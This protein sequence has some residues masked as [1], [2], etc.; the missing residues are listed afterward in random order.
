ML[1]DLTPPLR[2]LQ[3]QPFSR[4]FLPIHR[5]AAAVVAAVAGG[6]V[7]ASLEQLP[8][9]PQLCIPAGTAEA[10]TIR[11]EYLARARRP[12]PGSHCLMASTPRTGNAVGKAGHCWNRSR[13]QEPAPRDHPGPPTTGTAMRPH[14][15][16]SASWWRAITKLHGGRKGGSRTGRPAEPPATTALGSLRDRYSATPR[17]TPGQHR[18]P[19]LGAGGGYRRHNPAGAPRGSPHLHPDSGVAA[20]HLLTATGL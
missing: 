16:Q 6:R 4:L 8:A 9:L 20:G 17:T 12:H 14:Q 18:T 1:A 15:Q 19:G 2:C 13:G 3:L 5:G 11:A 10:C 7:E